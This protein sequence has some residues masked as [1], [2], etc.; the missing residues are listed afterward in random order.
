MILFQTFFAHIW[1]I[2]YWNFERFI[3]N[4]LTRSIFELEKCSLFLNGSEFRHDWYHYQGASPAPT[5][6]VRHQAMT[7]TPTRWSVTSE[8]S[9]PPPPLDFFHFLGI[10]LIR[11]LPLGNLCLQLWRLSLWTS[12]GWAPP[13]CPPWPPNYR[14]AGIILSTKKILLSLFSSR[15]S[16]STLIVKA[17]PIIIIGNRT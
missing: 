8:P 17:M 7:K 3:I 16:T 15:L 4:A 6:I 11:M 9:V 12:L 14:T 5:C 10:F 13:D 1:E 2:Y